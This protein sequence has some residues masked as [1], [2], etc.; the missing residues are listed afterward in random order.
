MT[1]PATAPVVERVDR[2]HRY[3]IRVG[4]ET[5]G[6]AAYRDRDGQRVFHHTEID[7]AFTGRGLA[8]VLVGR[9]L[10]DTRDA[11]KRVVPVCPYVAAHLR[12]HREFAG[13]SDPVTPQILQWL[14]GTPH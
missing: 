4:G 7:D 3:E 10:A 9:A 5:I 2:L 1:R 12:R 11:G 6:F 8:S 13:I 14:D